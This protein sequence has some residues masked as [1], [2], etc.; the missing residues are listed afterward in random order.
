MIKTELNSLPTELDEKQRKIL[1]MEIE[2]QALKKEDDEI[3]AQQEANPND[4][5]PLDGIW[6]DMDKYITIGTINQFSKKIPDYYKNF[7]SDDDQKKFEEM[8]D[9]IRN[10]LVLY[11]VNLA[12]IKKIVTALDEYRE[13]GVFPTQTI[14]LNHYLSIAA[15]DMVSVSSKL[16]SV[17]NGENCFGFAYLKNWLNKNYHSVPE[18]L[19]V[20][21]DKKTKSLMIRG[22]NYRVKF[23]EIRNHYLAHYDPSKLNA[24]EKFKTTQEELQEIFDLCIDVLE[25]LSFKYFDRQ[26]PYGMLIKLHGF[27]H[28]CQNP[29][30][31][32]TK[33]CDLDDFL[34]CLKKSEIFPA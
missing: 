11:S 23:E 29:W 16:F 6:A 3:A 18:V 12:Y 14:F 32:Q 22:E 8:L 13:K 24:I 31:S 33:R 27:S 1:Q 25:R 26:L 20:I 21:N 30:V 5:S 17:T 28:I 19:S 15:L 34:D 2:A 10:E 7:M 4:S 9:F